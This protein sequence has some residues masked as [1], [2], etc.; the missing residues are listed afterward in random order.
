MF[1]SPYYPDNYHDFQDCQWIIT[2]A[3]GYVI[4]LK[5]DVFEL[6]FNPLSCDRCNCDY[7]DV[8][9][10]TVSGRKTAIGRYCMTFA[11][12]PVIQSSSNRMIIAFHSDHAV[13]AK[14]FNASYT[15]FRIKGN[16]RLFNS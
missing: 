1:S 13:L 5:F 2:V 16:N 9:E 12:P 15:S 6:E 8:W 14:G 3:E 7:V 4:Q 11:P 10:E